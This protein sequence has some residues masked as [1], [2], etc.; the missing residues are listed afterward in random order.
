MAAVFYYLIIKPLSLLPLWAL[1]LLSDLFYLVAY[2]IARYRV[3]VVSTNLKNSFPNLSEKELVKM[4]QQ[5]YRHFCDVIVESIKIFSITQ[6]EVSARFIVTNP[7]ILQPFVDKEQSILIVG[8]HYNNWEMM[9]VGLDAHLEH[10]SVAIYHA[11]KNK[12]FDKKILASRSKFGLKL[13]SR[14]DVKAFFAN[15]TALT[16]TIFGADQSP[17][18]AKKVYWTHFL[19][20]E[21]AVMFGVEKFAKE[22]N[23]PVVFVGIRKVKR[24]YYELYF[25]VLFTEPALCA[26]GEITETH[27]RRLEQQILEAPQYWLW[28][29]KRWKRKKTEEERLEEQTSEKQ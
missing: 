20:Q 29:H 26:Y 10:Q 12:F 22:K 11:L 17:S 24:G 1:Y 18:I 6:E 27:V 19:N 14:P 15:N 28:T 9:A 4:R 8:G 13:I 7:E 16:A 25:E 21:T 23:S 3:T 2:K 5:F